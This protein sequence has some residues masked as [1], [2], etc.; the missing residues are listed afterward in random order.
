MYDVE[1]RRNLIQSFKL[2]KQVDIHVWILIPII[3]KDVH[4]LN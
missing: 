4:N 1:D 2:T 3:D